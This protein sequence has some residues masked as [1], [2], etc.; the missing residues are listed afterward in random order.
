MPRIAFYTHGLVD[1]GAERLW[2]CLASA[3]KT[4]G[5]D[6]QF[7]QDFEASDNRPNLRSDIPVHTLGT[8]HF[9][10]TWRLAR[11]LSHLKPDIVFSAVGASNPKLMAAK[12]LSVSPTRT[13]ITYHGFDEWKSGFLSRLAYQGLPV[14]SRL[15]TRTVTVSEGLKLV[16]LKHWRSY[17]PKTVTI[18]NPVF[19]P[20]GTEAPSASE[21]RAREPVIL[22]VGRLVPEKDFA[23]LLR[24]F[25]RVQTPGARLV[26]L[27]KGPERESLEALARELG[28]TERVSMPGYS[29]EPWHAYQT[30]K[31][32]AL[33]SICEPFGNVIVEALAHG[34]PVVA[35]NR[36][37]PREI[38][39]NGR[40]GV[41]V[42]R[43][44][45]AALAKAIDDA[46]ADPGDPEAGHRRAMDFS[47]EVRVPE[48]VALIE[49]ILGT[50]RS[51]ITHA[52]G[53]RLASG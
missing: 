28:I 16:L 20:A 12:A 32:F 51:E 43:K 34:L 11:L 18:H 48:Y 38:L 29:Q 23:T 26:I 36:A 8:N 4:R 22:A 41:L 42:R 39:D 33:S 7:I 21:L 17:E 50:S 9:L 47:F 31:V 6:V 30:A 3:I 45:P 13:V 1:G 46:L 5:F 35:T 19:F 2:A 40:Y 24:A 10:A 14:L 44:N 25:T 15:A 49:E 53:G 27:G 37:G 52:A